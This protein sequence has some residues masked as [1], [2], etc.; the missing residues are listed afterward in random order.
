MRY[1]CDSLAWINGTTYY[2]DTIVYDTL[3]NMNGCDSTCFIF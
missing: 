3:Q 2:N 1:E